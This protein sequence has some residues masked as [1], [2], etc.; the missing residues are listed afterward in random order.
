MERHQPRSLTQLQQQQLQI[1]NVHQE[2]KKRTN[3]GERLA[4]FITER[5][6]SIQFFLLIVTWTVIWI[7]WN[8]F[9][10]KALRF[11]PSPDFLLWLFI[12]NVI[13][14][15][16]MPLIMVGQTLQGRKDEI[17]AKSDYEVNIKSE[18]EI[19]TIL[20]HLENQSREL[21]EIKRLLSQ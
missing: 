16:L 3:W 8:S 10:P 13:Q 4:L 5:V 19:E 7:S 15:M 9:S 18:E 1:K 21:E 20:Q 14:I 17:R 12:S 11:D 2:F 6:G